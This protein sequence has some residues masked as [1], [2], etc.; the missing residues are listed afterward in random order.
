MIVVDSS[1]PIAIPERE[2]D[3]IVLAA[4]IERAVRLFISAVNVH[5]TGVALFARH[6]SAAV[7]R[8]WRFLLLDDDFDIV[9]F[10]EDQVRAALDALE[11]YGK[12]VHPRA[13]LNLADCCAYALAR[14]LGLPLLFKGAAVSETGIARCL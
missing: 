11:T 3:A 12:G 9:A 14:R 1:A 6:G 4:A 2:E 8:L 10:D 7:D 13:R 5:E